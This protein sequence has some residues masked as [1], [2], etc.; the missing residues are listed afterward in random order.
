MGFKLS[1]VLEDVLNLLSAVL[2]YRILHSTLV[3][4]WNFVD[5][6]F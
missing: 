2:K 5:D 6:R 4:C 3:Y 1:V